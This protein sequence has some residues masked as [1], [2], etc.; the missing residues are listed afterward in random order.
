MMDTQQPIIG[1]TKMVA[2]VRVPNVPDSALGDGMPDFE[3][4]DFVQEEMM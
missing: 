1:M 4:T 3:I 2:T